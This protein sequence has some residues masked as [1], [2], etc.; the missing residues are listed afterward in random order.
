MGRKCYTEYC[1]HMMR[2]FL[3][4]GDKPEGDMTEVEKQNI[5]VCRKVLN[6]LPDN[7][8]GMIMEIYNLKPGETKLDGVTRASQK[9]D[10]QTQSIYQ[11]SYSFERK[12]A[13]ERGLI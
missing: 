8:R 7:E 10:L 12:I 9:Y 11:I 1:I 6:E 13:K 5:E 4:K 3:F 2:F